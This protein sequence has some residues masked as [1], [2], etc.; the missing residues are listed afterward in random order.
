VLAEATPLAPIKAITPTMELYLELVTLNNEYADVLDNERY[1]EFP[2]FFVEDCV[3][4]VVPRE[5][6]LLGLPIA[7]IHCESKGMVK[8]RV[9]AARESTMAEP[10]TFRHFISNIRVLEASDQAIRAQANVLIVQTMI[11]RM[12]EIVLAGFYQ[13]QIVRQDGRFLFKERLC[14]YD[15]LLLPTSMIAPV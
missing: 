2:D 13:D 6:H 9:Y 10:R 8:D 15:S 4:R 3:Y 1:D 7:V 12:T 5:N 11:N 14:I